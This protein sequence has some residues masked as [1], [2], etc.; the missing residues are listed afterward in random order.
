[1]EL[2]A[3][4]VHKSWFTRAA[5]VLVTTVFAVGA[6]AYF[7][8]RPILWCAL[9]A[10]SLPLTMFVFVALPVLRQESHKS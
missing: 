9:I 4:Q 2:T 5:L 6:T 7:V 10:S 1:M 8:E 3:F